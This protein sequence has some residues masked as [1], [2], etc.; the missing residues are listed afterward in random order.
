MTT[1][2]LAAA[3]H[4]KRIT[5]MGLGRFG[6]AVGLIRFLSA[7]SPR[8]TVTDSASPETLADSVQAIADLE[9]ITLQLGVSQDAAD[10]DC[11][12]LF[13]NPGVPPAHPLPRRAQKNGALPATEIGLFLALF[14]G[15]VVA[16]T[17]TCGKS[18]TS[19]LIAAMLEAAGRN[20]FLGGNVGGSLLQKLDEMDAESVAVVELS[21]FQLHYLRTCRPEF[22][23]PDIALLLNI[24]DDH[25]NWHGS[26]QAYAQSKQTIF[27]PAG[28]TPL[29]WA[30]IPGDD[31]RILDAAHKSG[32]R[33][34]AVGSAPTH[35]QCWITSTASFHTNGITDKRNETC[36]H[37]P[38]FEKHELRLLGAVNHTNALFAASAAHLL[39]VPQS[40]IREAV[41]NFE[42]LND[43]FEHAG[44]VRGRTFIN[45]SVATTPHEAAAN[46]RIIDNPVLLI[47]GGAAGKDQS[48]IPLAQ[49]A[50]RCCRLAV[51]VG[52]TAEEL[53][54]TFVSVAPGI[55]RFSADTLQKAFATCT[56]NSAPGDT[57]LFAPGAPSFDAFVNFQARGEAFRAC[58]QAYR[59]KDSSPW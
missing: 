37:G 7:F 49:A 50:K 24:L 52:Q 38:L 26:Y 11:D 41:R 4:K 55:R 12:L 17:G 59:R 51:F 35:A 44:T 56:D 53:N 3:L 13:I 20:T 42:G 9:G 46:L 18:T 8:L 57:I 40:A 21:S 6:G 32:R 19:A 14:P 34:C 27:R 45:S 47:A 39:S 43:R 2:D 30:V 23:P 22:R 58:V 33:I 28:G 1:A 16:V 54:R 36:T 15:T 25:R 48:F 5:V 31:A 10:I 29:N